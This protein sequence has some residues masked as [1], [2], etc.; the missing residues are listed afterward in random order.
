LTPVPPGANAPLRTTPVV[1]A[2]AVI[3]EQDFQQAVNRAIADIDSIQVATIDFVPGGIHVELTALGGVA[4]V[5]GEVQVLIQ[6]SGSFATIS[7]GEVTVN[8][9]EPTDTYLEVVS[10]DFF[11]MLVSVFDGL[12]T[13]RVGPDHD[14]ENIVLTDAAME[15]FLLVPEQ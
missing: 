3:T 8:G 12:L 14:L 1:M 5:T 4:F 11:T 10:G 13:E 15:V 9:G 6:M 2:D 7:I